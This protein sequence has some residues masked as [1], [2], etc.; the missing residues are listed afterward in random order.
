MGRSYPSRCRFR[1]WRVL[2][3]SCRTF[4][5]VG[6]SYGLNGA[7][8]S[9]ERTHTSSDCAGN[10]GSS[11]SLRGVSLL[12]LKRSR[13]TRILERTVPLHHNRPCLRRRCRS[14]RGAPRHFPGY[15]RPS[16]APSCR[17]LEL[18]R[19]V[20]YRE[21][22]RHRRALNRSRCLLHHVCE[23]MRDQPFPA[24]HA[25]R[26]FPFTE[27]PVFPPPIPVAIHHPAPSPPLPSLP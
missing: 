15:P 25:R 16:V 17:L 2:G 10:S 9:G 18:V 23:L 22:V 27:T 3:G 13:P 8:H 26:I 20:T 11:A 14:T 7:Q 24:R 6:G 5:K 1:N 21:T 19:R 12:F 4:R